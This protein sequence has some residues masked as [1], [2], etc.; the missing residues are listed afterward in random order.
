MIRLFRGCLMV[1]VMAL[2]ASCATLTEEEC[3]YADWYRIGVT[4]GRAGQPDA[5]LAQHA[6]A[7]EKHGVRPDADAWRGG[8]SDGIPNYCSSSSGWRQGV[9]GTSY[10]GVCPP[11]LEEDFLFGYER[12]RALH[13]VGN[14]LDN[15]DSRITTLETLVVDDEIEEAERRDLMAE[16]RDLQREARA[17]E[18]ERALIEAEAIERGLR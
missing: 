4:D 13:A 12:G 11:A 6:E 3:R 2:L 8:W 9:A 15:I 10:S 5:R 18:R 16:L 14:E 1:S 7:C 17:L